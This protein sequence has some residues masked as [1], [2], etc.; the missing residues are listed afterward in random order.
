MTLESQL[1]YDEG[2]RNKAY[3][4]SLGIWTIGVGHTGKEVKSGLVWTDKQI[5]D[6]LAI[7]I[8]S[9]RKIAEGFT[10]FNSL[11]DPRKAAV[12]NMCFQLGNKLTQ[13]T[14]MLGA[15]RD[16]K[17]ALAET[18]GLQSLWAQQT[19]KRAKRVLR[20]LAS[21]NWEY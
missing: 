6:Q 16:E 13:F 12:I 7:D 19:P 5:N 1:K 17:Y 15:I 8:D 9:A 11:N 3:K 2:V 10:F 21:G 18:Y 14:R 20:Q 4:D